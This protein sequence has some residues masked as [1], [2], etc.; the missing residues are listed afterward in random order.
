MLPESDCRAV[1]SWFKG[2]SIY[3]PTEEEK[4]RARDAFIWMDLNTSDCTHFDDRN[5][6]VAVFSENFALP[7]CDVERLLNDYV[8]QADTVQPVIIGIEGLDGSGKTVQAKKLRDFL[9]QRGKSVCMIDFPQYSSFFGKEIG[10]LLSNAGTVSA[11]ELDEKSM[12]LW[13]GLDR[14]NTVNRAQIE[15]YDYVIF[16]RY[17]LSNVVYQSARRY[18]GLHQQFADWIFELEHIQLALP[19]PDLYIFL[20]TKSEFCSAN[21]LRKG[22]REYVDGLDVYE[23]SKDLQS[24][25]HTIY[26]KL[27]EEIDEVLFLECVDDQGS[28]RDM[29]E[30]HS[31]I[32]ANLTKYGLL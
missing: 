27:A 14:W 3:F 32:I 1:L 6:C 22:E 15:K 17:T 7:V 26:R 13:Y 23:K 2:A 20:N 11:M 25:C 16:N 10:A 21:V 28:M 30:I 8:R 24:C 19:V 5:E 9:E 31:D 12:C 4:K 29:E 18:G